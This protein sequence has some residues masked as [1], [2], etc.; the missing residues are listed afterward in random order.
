MSENLSIDEIIKRAEKIKAEAEKQLQIAEKN[1]DEKAKTVIDDVVVDENEVVNRIA[2][3]YESVS[4]KDDSDVKEYVPKK[5]SEFSA[6]KTK[7]IDIKQTDDDVKIALPVDKNKTQPVSLKSDG[8]DKQKTGIVQL[9]KTGTKLFKREK[10][11]DLEKTKPIAFV[12][13]S[14]KVGKSGLESIPTIVARQQIFND[15]NDLQEEIGVQMTFDGFDDTIETVPTI[16]EDVAEQILEQRRQEKVGKFRLFGPDETDKELGNSDV[17]HDYESNGKRDEFISNLLSKRIAIQVRLVITIALG[18]VLLLMTL[19]TDSPYFPGWLMPPNKA[20]FITS[21]IVYLAVIIV[22]FN[23]IIRGFKIK[24][25]ISSD[26]PIA[27]T[28]LMVLI[29]TFAMAVFDDLWFENHIMLASVGVLALFM[30]Q[31]GKHKMMTRVIDN[32]NFIIS[33]NSGYT[34]ENITNAVD[35]QIIARGFIDEEPLIKTSVKTDFTTNFFEIECK[36]EPANKIS[37]VTYLVTLVANL[38]LFLVMAFTQNIESAINVSLCGLTVSLPMSALFLSNSVLENIS[39][40]LDK[41]GS[42]VCGYEGASMAEDSNAMVM[43]AAD[44]FGKQSCDIHGIKTF[45]DAKIDDAIIQAAAV[46]IQ[47]NSPLAHAFDDVIIGKQSI[48]P[49]VEGV[50]YEDKMGTSAWIYQRKVLVGNRNLLIRH[51]VAVPPES[52]EEKYTVKGRKALYLAVA[53]KIVAMFVVSYSADVDLKRQLKKLEKSGIT[54]I[55][56]SS[57]PYINEESISKLFALPKGFIRVMNYS[58]ARVYE[59]YSNQ[60]VEKSPA[61]VVH[62]G[63]ALGF[64]SAMHGAKVITGSVN[65]ISFLVLFG[66]LLGFGV[67]AMLA[68]VG[69]FS[70]LNPVSLILFQLVWT[71]FMSAVLKLRCLGF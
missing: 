34:V 15:E 54:I 12:S 22:N 48:L 40:A 47:T 4:Q 18:I 51:G 63:T 49:K 8:V 70:Q 13:K 31:C 46:I 42:R 24:K 21:A 62:N 35:A 3:R 45:Y 5:S 7:I 61:Y 16:D 11:V 53:G 60:A 65:L 25:S 17:K 36:K 52:F 9:K 30:S 66:A 43:E 20:Y 67:V 19:F 23:V 57:D 44:L 58:A 39:R 71:G 1:L 26:F 28:S 38:I 69:A 64:V 55:V 29:H 41:Y 6:Y 14:E 37:T 2:Q 32:F 68:L 33:S 59:K 27:I 50:T 56:K 10:S